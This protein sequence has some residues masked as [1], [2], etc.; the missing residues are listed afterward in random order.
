MLYTTKDKDNNYITFDS[1]KDGFFAWLNY[2][3][4]EYINTENPEGSFIGFLKSMPVFGIF[5]WVILILLSPLIILWGICSAAFDE[6]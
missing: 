1:D 3:Y 4:T 5:F 6:D 2:R